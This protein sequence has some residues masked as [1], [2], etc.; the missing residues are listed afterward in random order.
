[1]VTRHH[2]KDYAAWRKVYDAFA[3]RQQSGGV[4]QQSVYQDASDPNDVL[5]LHSFA[6]RATAEAFI[7]GP[8]LRSAMENAGVDSAPRIELFEEAS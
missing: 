8:E 3:P 2:V 5:V 1:M 6:D 7:H 4:T